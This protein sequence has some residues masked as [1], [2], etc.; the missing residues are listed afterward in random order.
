MLSEKVPPWGFPLAVAWR[1]TRFSNLLDFLVVAKIKTIRK[2]VLFG[3]LQ[4]ASGNKVEDNKNDIVVVGFTNSSG[5]NPLKDAALNSEGNYVCSYHLRGL[6]P[7][8]VTPQGVYDFEKA[9]AQF[10]TD[11]PIGYEDEDVNLYDF[12]VSDLCGKPA[13]KLANGN[14]MQVRRIASYA[15]NESAFQTAKND[16]N[17]NFGTKFFDVD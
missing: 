3:M 6:Y 4:D 10:T 9:F 5:N 11:Y 1:N 8:F 17:K 15:S 16:M 13:V 2:S 14:I 7:N 12:P